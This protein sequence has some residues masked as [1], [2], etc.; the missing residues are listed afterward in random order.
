MSI[1][2]DMIAV[3][4][5]RGTCTGDLVDANGCVCVIGAYAYAKGM[6]PTIKGFD[7]NWPYTMAAK[8]LVSLKKVILAMN[9]ALEPYQTGSTLFWKYND[10]IARGR[11]G[12]LIFA[13]EQADELERA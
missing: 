11:Q 13:L 5:E 12:V 6:D 1:Y 7:L 9:P 4:K 10:R 3:M 8:E 2:T